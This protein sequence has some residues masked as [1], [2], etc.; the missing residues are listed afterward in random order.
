MWQGPEAPVGKERLTPKDRESKM[1]AML[2]AVNE[3]ISNGILVDFL[4][5]NKSGVVD[6]YITEW[7]EDA[8][9]EALRQEA[10]EEGRNKINV[11]N[12]FLI[13]D[14]R[15]EDLKRSTTDIEF[16]N[17]LLVEY[18]IETNKNS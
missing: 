15:I 17:K 4:L 14:N 1:Q 18:G 7:D 10:N 12:Q 11:L 16:Q 8:Y 9:R 13:R 5:K 6:M 3:C 2:E